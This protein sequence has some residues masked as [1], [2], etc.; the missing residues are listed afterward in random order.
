MQGFKHLV[1]CRCILPQLKRRKNPPRH[2]FVVFSIVDETD[3]V[4]QKYVQCPSCGVVH[5]VTEISKSEIQEGKEHMPSIVTIDDIRNSLDE[6]IAAVLDSNHTDISV[7]EEIDFA[8]ENEEWGRYI[9]LN[10]DVEGD[11]AHIKCLRILGPKLFKV[12]N[13]IR[14]D[15]AR[16]NK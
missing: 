10:K 11:E 13:E 7:W 2:Q 14:E 15:V 16:E 6:K 8:I 12:I 9:V 5:K 1:Q 4:K 3:N